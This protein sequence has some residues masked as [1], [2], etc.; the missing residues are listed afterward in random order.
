M[1]R[2]RTAALGAEVSK[3]QRTRVDVPSHSLM[4]NFSALCN[5]SLEADNAAMLPDAECV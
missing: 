2:F 3:D 5:N 1:P 4:A